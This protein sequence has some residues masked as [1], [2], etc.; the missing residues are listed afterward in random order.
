MTANIKGI[1]ST[2][3]IEFIEFMKLTTRSRFGLRFILNLGLNYGEGPVY[4]KEISQKEEISEKYLSQLAL[5]LK[6]AGLISSVRGVRGGYVLNRKPSQI[7]LLE[8]IKALE[9]DLNLVPCI[10]DVP[11]CSKIAVCATREVWL[12]MENALKDVLNSITLEDLISVYKEKATN[13][14]YQI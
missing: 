12:R 14:S 3:S 4:L 11:G 7:K 6:S 13:L 1:K 9:G 8:V 5:F 2:N 10:Q